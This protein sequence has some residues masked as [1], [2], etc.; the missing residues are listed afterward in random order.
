MTIY[1]LYALIIFHI[2]IWIFSIFGGLISKTFA[3]FNI[4]ILLPFIYIFQ[5]LPIH[6]IIWIKIYII[7]SE[8]INNTCDMNQNKNIP[9]HSIVKKI[10]NSLN[11]STQTIQNNFDTLHCYDKDFIIGDLFYQLRDIFQNS[12]LNPLSPQGLIILGYIINSYSLKYLYT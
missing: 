6:L 3:L 5:S 11:V 9:K 7:N 10:A 2:F 1:L 12:F 8:G 4:Y